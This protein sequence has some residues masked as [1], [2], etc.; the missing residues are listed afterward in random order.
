MLR[1]T[2]AMIARL[3]NIKGALLLVALW[4]PLNLFSHESTLNPTSG[5]Q[6]TTFYLSGS[7]TISASGPTTFCMGDSVELSVTDTASFY[8]WYADTDEDIDYP[9]YT[10]DFHLPDEFYDYLTPLQTT[11]RCQEDEDGPTYCQWVDGISNE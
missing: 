8:Q 6:L 4:H 9:S 11:D 10:A 7:Y 2:T 1:L 5:L 3:L